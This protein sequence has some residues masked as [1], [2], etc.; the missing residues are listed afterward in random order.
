LDNENEDEE[1]TRSMTEGTM[2][3]YIETTAIQSSEEHLRYLRLQEELR[4]QKQLMKRRYDFRL[5]I[6]EFVRPILNID[7][8]DRFAEINSKKDF[9]S[10]ILPTNFKA[11][12][13][14][15]FQKWEHLFL[16][17]T[18]NMLLNSRRSDAKE[19]DHA[20]E[21][22]RKQGLDGVKETKTNLDSLPLEVSSRQI[23]RRGNKCLHWIGY[24]VC[25]Q[26]DMLFQNIKM[27]EKPPHSG[28]T[29][30]ESHQSDFS[31][32]QVR[33]HDLLILSEDEIDLRGQQDIKRVSSISFLRGLLFK[34]NAMFAFVTKRAPASKNGSS[35]A[36]L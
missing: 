16:Y 18:Y 26:K 23:S 34:H 6:D 10:Y 21:M 28:A 32:K 24:I 12:H 17:E 25:G 7:I 35:A 4:I 36:T 27:Y 19:E 3:E 20:Q 2:V 22:I 15:Y 11:G 14:E 30:N 33:E 9:E 8:L 5:D 29:D 31:L 1:Y 13:F